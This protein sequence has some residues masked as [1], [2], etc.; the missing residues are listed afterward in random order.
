MSVERVQQSGAMSDARFSAIACV[1][2]PV[3]VADVT[4]GAV[5]STVTPTVPL[6]V[7]LVLVP[8]STSA[9]GVC[10]GC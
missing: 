5:G 3:T 7:E 1:S 9:T 10:D 2:T 4:V 6:A 8:V